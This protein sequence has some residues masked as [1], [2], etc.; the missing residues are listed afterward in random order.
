[1]TVAP[2]LLALHVMCI[3]VIPRVSLILIALVNEMLSEPVVLME[4]AKPPI[5]LLL[6]S[7]G[8]GNSGGDLANQRDLRSKSRSCACA[9]A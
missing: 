7:A 8:G 9:C 3:I 5:F 6:R 2:G 1:L 4:V